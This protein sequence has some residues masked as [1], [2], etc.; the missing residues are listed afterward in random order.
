MSQKGQKQPSKPIEGNVRASGAQQSSVSSSQAARPSSGFSAS[1]LN[2]IVLEYLNKKGYHRTEQM[3]RAESSRTLTPSNKNSA[4]LN[5]LPPPSST[6]N[7]EVATNGKPVSN[8]SLPLKRDANNNIIQQ[9]RVT[10]QHYFRAY[11]MLKNWIDS[12][13]DMYRP[14]LSRIIYPI[15]I[16]VFLTLVHKDPVQARRFF[17]KYSHDFKALHGSEINK[18][19]SVN[20]VDHI[21]ENELAQG[22]QSNKYR[23]SISRTTLNLLLYFL[24]EN[25]SVG[26]SLL[27][28]IIN[29]NLEPNAVDNITSQETL[30][31]GIKDVSAGAIDVDNHNSVPVKL[32]PFPIDQEFTKEVEVELKRKDEQENEQ[33]P[34]ENRR[35]LLEEYKSMTGQDSNIQDPNVYPTESTSVQKSEDGEIPEKVEDKSSEKSSAPNSAS[36]QSAGEKQSGPAPS[37]ASA[38]LASVKAAASSPLNPM[39]ESPLKDVLPLPPKTA[40]DL[41]LEIQ[42]VR[43]S[44]DAIR[45]DNFQV[46]APSVCMYT[47]HN[48]NRDMTCLQFSDDSRL[49][50]A[51]F[52]GSYIRIWS[53]DGSQLVSKLSSKSKGEPTNNVTLIGHSGP[54]YSLSFSP[55]NRYLVSAS[56]DMTVRL[57][58]L[59]SFTCLVSYNGHN[60][61]VWDV[62]FSPLGHYF[63]TGSH[64]QTA[65]LWSCDHI[66]P[67]RIFAGHLNDVDCV[68]FHPNGTYVLT[69]SSDKTCRMW[70]IQT[71]DSVRLFL[72][73]TASVVSVAVSPDGRWLTTGS[74]D[75]IIIVWDIGTGKRIKQMRGHGKSAVYSLSFNKEG[76]ILVSGGAD[77]S[78]RVWDLKKFTN[79]PGLEPEQ[80]YTGYSGDMETSVNQD[81]KEY[82]RRRTVFPTQDLLAS[83]HT[84]R[85]PIYTVKFTRSNLVLAGGAFAE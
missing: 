84:K 39:M 50:A 17:D 27:I 31:D 10:P 30:T 51:G 2:R 67:L 23:V 37:V 21:K 68:A 24:N 15:F 44:R 6:I 56:E 74:E 71:G 77:Q 48:T 13:L 26:G 54:V 46:S 29:Q 4:A 19:F 59:D 85:T 3:L 55:D 64:D 47:F 66:Y 9:S 75:G 52:Q 76:N 28:S 70:D 20:S 16:Y 62:K 11:A 57:W 82:G 60:H 49:L 38:A 61:P 5:T 40:L 32:G 34:D 58:S 78:V 12:S 73:H 35:T 83:F 42:K 53:L 18:L 25:E 43:E 72:G 8:P 14:E 63:V 36:G 65:R 69:G 45:L 1:D 41:K 7:Q 22:F 80:Q 33:N 79:E 81:V